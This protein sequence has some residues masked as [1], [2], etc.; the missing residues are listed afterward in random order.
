MKGLI[1]GYTAGRWQIWDQVCLTLKPQ[2]ITAQS[3][4]CT[5]LMEPSL[6]ERQAPLQKL[7]G[8]L[9]EWSHSLL[10]GERRTR[11]LGQWALLKAIILKENLK[12]SPYNIHYY[13]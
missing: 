9:Q 7:L 4:D 2:G 6:L 3:S 12:T 13:A 10:K 5:V 1:Q 8:R 11:L